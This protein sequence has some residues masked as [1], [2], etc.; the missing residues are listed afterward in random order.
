MF[1]ASK[2]FE[3]KRKDIRD[4]VLTSNILFEKVLMT[5][6]SLTLLQVS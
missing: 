2:I 5:W 4:D 3:A 1:F 6:V